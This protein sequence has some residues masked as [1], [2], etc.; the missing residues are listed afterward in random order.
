MKSLIGFWF[1]LNNYN[2]FS[3]VSEKFQNKNLEGKTKPKQNIQLHL[4]KKITLDYVLW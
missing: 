1:L 3:G 2:F 4:F